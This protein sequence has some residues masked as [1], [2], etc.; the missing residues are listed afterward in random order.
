[1]ATNKNL[2]IEDYNKMVADEEQ[3]QL[4]A[5]EANRVLF[6]ANTAPLK[7]YVRQYLNWDRVTY[8]ISDADDADDILLTISKYKHAITHLPKHIEG[9]ESI[10]ITA[11]TEIFDECEL[12]RFAVEYV[13]CIPY[14][15]DSKMLQGK[16]TEKVLHKIS[17]A[18]QPASSN[19]LR[20][21]NCDLL[22]TFKAG[23]IDWQTM[24]EIVYSD[25]LTGDNHAKEYS[26]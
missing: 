4:A 25:C 16:I 2:T 3:V 12:E 18:L 20:R 21:I 26:Y 24:K 17:K 22:N 11:D 14:D 13:Y 7:D 8:N 6:A 23:K 1:M 10:N 19:N 9:V 15:N 5:I